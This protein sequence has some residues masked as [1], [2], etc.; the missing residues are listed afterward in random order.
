MANS[1]V[2]ELSKAIRAFRLAH[3]GVR[4]EL[5]ADT[6][7]QVREFVVLEGVDAILLDNM[8]TGELR[9]AVRLRTGMLAF[10]ASGG[11][12]LETV[13]AIA[14]TGVDFISVG[15]LTHSAPA[16]D[17]SLELLP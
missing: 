11:V 10:E 6:L 8:S 1:G 15:A 4:I 17:F 16:I 7:D 5:E 3:P 12:S 14:S 9:E 2:E 13:G